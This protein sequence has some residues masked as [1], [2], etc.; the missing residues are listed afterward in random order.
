MVLQVTM[1]VTVFCSIID[2]E[3]SQLVSYGVQTFLFIILLQLC[4]L[5]EGLN[6]NHAVKVKDLD[7]SV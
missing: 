3:R 4:A 2:Q 1:P 7:Q 5:L 6:L